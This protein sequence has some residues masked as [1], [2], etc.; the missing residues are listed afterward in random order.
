M[1]NIP[2]VIGLLL[3]SS[4]AFAED[5]AP[6]ILI[7]EDFMWNFNVLIG[8]LSLIA[9]LLA[10]IALMLVIKRPIEDQL[11]GF[12]CQLHWK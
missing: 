8:L 2:L 5:V 9:F 12:D 11:G 1:K 4:P 6:N 3:L 7:K 10:V